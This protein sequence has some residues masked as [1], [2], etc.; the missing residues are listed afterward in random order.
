MAVVVRMQRPP[1][2]TS[3]LAASTRTISA[4][5]SVVADMSAVDDSLGKLADKLSVSR[6]E[7]ARGIVRIANSNMV[8]ALKTGF[9]STGATT[10]ETSL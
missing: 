2:P 4:A 6:E 5:V 9:R 8:N 10:H 1:M 7:V 3:R